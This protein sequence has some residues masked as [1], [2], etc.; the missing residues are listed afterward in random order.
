LDRAL[1]LIT[2]GF[3]AETAARVQAALSALPAGL[4]AVQLRAKTLDGRALYEAACRLREVTLERA[5]LF[6]NDRIDVALAAGADGVHL[7]A[8]GLPPGPARR[9]ITS[10]ASEGGGRRFY[11]GCSTHSLAEAQACTASARGGADFVTFGPV[12]HTG[13][14]A[15]FGP[16]VGVERL[17]EVVRTL[18]VPVFAL[19]GVDV[20]RTPAC[21]S[22]GAQVAC[23]GAV[24]GSADPAGGARAIARAIG[25]S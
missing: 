7:P 22:V 2:D 4:A 17:G 14:K 9:A 5:L 1:Y 8:R 12:F 11:V 16:P 3:D 13:S 18:A 25:Y 6:V 24:L 23:I 21:R 15:S 10:A 19:G 20:V